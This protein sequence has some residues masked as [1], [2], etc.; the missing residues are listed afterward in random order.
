MKLKTIDKVFD[1]LLWGIF[2]ILIIFSWKYNKSISAPDFEVVDSDVRFPY[3]YTTKDGNRINSEYRLA[4]KHEQ[5]S[6]PKIVVYD[7]SNGASSTIKD[8]YIEEYKTIM[9]DSKYSFWNRCFWLIFIV[10]LLLSA[11][12]T[13]FVGGLIRDFVLYLITISRNTF[14]D[15]SY[16]LYHNRICFK[17]QVRANITKT[18][19]KYIR[20]QKTA[21][22]K[23]YVPSFANLVIQLLDEIKEQEDTRVRFYY[24]YL[25]NTQDQM[26]YLKQLSLY[27]KSQ[28]GK[29][30]DAEKKQDYIDGLRQKKYVKFSIDATA[31]DFVGIVSEEL[32]KLFS[33]VMGEEVFN[34]EAY[35][36]AYANMSRMPGAIFVT[37]T[38]ENST[39]TFTWRGHGYSGEEFPGVAVRFTIYHYENNQKMILWNRYLNPKCTYRAEENSLVITD[40]YKNMVTETIRSFP[41]SLKN[42]K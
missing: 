36:S 25:D 18:I 20:T 14:S 31:S 19:D 16:F 12:I 23:R 13:Y 6:K 4:W 37:T 10:M 28:I 33:E 34:F 38:V 1:Y 41:E 5:F 9:P 40:V 42:S 30:P 24:S 21:L 2:I 35:H 8:E 39:N 15:C 26:E 7:P 22:F 3:E 11:S 27:W 17:K 32:K 29:D